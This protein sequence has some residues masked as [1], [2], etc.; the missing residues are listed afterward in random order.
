MYMKVAG[1]PVGGI[2]L[3]PP[4]RI[5]IQKLG[6]VRTDCIQKI[7]RIILVLRVNKINQRMVQLSSREIIREP[8]HFATKR[9]NVKKS[10]KIL[11]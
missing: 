2:A 7:A 1:V 5:W 3:L 4:K 6:A 9:S 8:R 10:T 11:Q